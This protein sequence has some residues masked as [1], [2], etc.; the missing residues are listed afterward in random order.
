MEKRPVNNTEFWHQ[1]LDSANEMGQ[2]WRSVYDTT[3][4]D[5]ERINTVHQK[6]I[7]KYIPEGARVLDAACGYGRL[8]PLF[9][10]DLYKGIDFSSDFILKAQSLYPEYAFF[11]HDLDESLPKEWEFDWALC[12]SLKGMIKRERGNIDWGMMEDNLRKNARNIL[13]LEYSVPEEYEVITYY[14]P[15]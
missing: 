5:W 13:I 14:T 11:V 9:S 10:P 3:A 15:E 12:V 7:R 8:A 6:L 4:E 1:R 2:L